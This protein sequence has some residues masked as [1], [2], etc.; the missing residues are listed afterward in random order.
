M[1]QASMSQGQD[2]ALPTCILQDSVEQTPCCLP[3]CMSSIDRVD[4]TLLPCL[5]ASANGQN[6]RWRRSACCDV[7]FPQ[8]Q[9][10][11]VVHTA[12]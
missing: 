3:A 2:L 7:V 11:F 12:P 1:V 9:D 5:T 8:D 10:L 4:Q 6:G